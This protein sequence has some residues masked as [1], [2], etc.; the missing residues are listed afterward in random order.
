MSA[1]HRA[2][3]LSLYQNELSKD[4]FIVFL[5]IGM[6]GEGGGQVAIHCATLKSFSP[7]L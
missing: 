2:L 7:T 3:N 5:G 4:S 6:Q 1:Q